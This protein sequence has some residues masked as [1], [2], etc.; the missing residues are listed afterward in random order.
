MVR[1]INAEAGHIPRAAIDAW[2]EIGPQRVRRALAARLTQ[3]EERGLLRVTD[4]ERAALHLMLLISS[5]APT[6]EAETLTNKQLDEM[7]TSGVRAF[8]HGYLPPS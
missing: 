1:Q 3:F 8:L 7:V 2:E 6:H 4:P 5:D